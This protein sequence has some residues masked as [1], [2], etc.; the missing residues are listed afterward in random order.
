DGRS[1]VVW[2]SRAA[3]SA[4]PA[5]GNDT[6]TPCAADSMA[7]GPGFRAALLPPVAARPPSPEDL[8]RCAAANDRAARPPPL[9]L[10][11]VVQGVNTFGRYSNARLAQADF[12]SLALHSGRSV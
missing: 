6:G 4:P 12:V 8:A 7:G 11:P 9:P 5:R 2:H 1:M 3:I 10:P